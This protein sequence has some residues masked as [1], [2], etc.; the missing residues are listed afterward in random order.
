[1]SRSLGTADSHDARRAVGYGSAMRV[2]PIR[3]KWVVAG[4]LGATALAAA[5]SF[6][7]LTRAIV[8]REAQKRHLD[9]VLGS[10][11]PGW[12]AVRLLDVRVHPIE[13]STIRA[14]VD[15]VRVGLTPLLGLA[16]LDVRGADVVLTGSPE[17]IREDWHRMRGE[18][19]DGPARSGRAIPVEA[20]GISVHWIDPAAPEL[21]A[22]LRGVAASHDSTGARLA[23]TDGQLRFGRIDV[24]LGDG[25]AQTDEHGRLVRAHAAALTVGWIS[26]G[27]PSLGAGAPATVAPAPALSPP[28]LV[29]RAARPGRRAR[30]AAVPPP[31]AGAPLIALPDLHAIRARASAL[32]ALLG[33]RVQPGADIGV[34]ALTWK[35]TQGTE[36]LALTFGPGPMALTRAPA[37]LELTYS[38]D[39]HG[40]SAPL[41]LRL[42]LPT[43]RGDVLVTG[44]GGP[45][46]LSLL[47]VQEGAAGLVDVDRATVAGRGRVVLAGD[48]TGLTFDGDVSTHGL[49]LNHPKLAQ[50]AVRGLDLTLRARGAIDGTGD[51]RLDD[52]AATL[53]TLRLTGSGSLEQKPDHV[54]AAARFDIPSAA[55]QSLLASLPS[56]LLPVLEE[57]RMKGTFAAHGRFAFDTRSLEDLE[58]RYEI[59]DHCQVEEVP[60]E[61]D[62]D[63][64]TRPFTHRIYLP[65]GSTADETTGPGTDNWAPLE[66]VSPYMQIAVLTT[67]DGAFPKHHGF[68]HAAIRSSI[69]ANLKAR[70][71]VR[72]AS[73]I[74]MQL[75]KNLFLSR[76]KT[77]SRK[78]E[79][80][81][82]TDYLEQTFTKDE[83][84]ELYLNVIE[85]GPAVYGI[86]A[87]ADYYFGRTPAELNLAESL[88]LASLLPAPLRYSAMREGE[89]PS[90]GWLRNLHALMEIERKRG[91]ITDAELSEGEQEQILFWHGGARPA[92]RAA[93]HVRTSISGSDSEIPDPFD[94]P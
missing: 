79:E 54:A 80:V 20:T 82:L 57:T 84:M 31:D 4:V 39:R 9:V 6:V 12:L 27:E 93:V 51:V 71:F 67:E 89:Q 36:R 65:D 16:H 83:I 86:T 8:S 30:S 17:S 25:A 3:Q 53:G 1:M 41:A 64:F 62:H 47:G 46:S 58:L 43:D 66:Q 32:A 78:L 87:G 55:C 50:E 40:A 76:D 2:R 91:L 22:E 61:L 48:G 68:N 59:A 69:V 60:V 92:P 21:G 49:S 19:D 52:F 72:G 37:Q 90:E 85:F 33:E 23:V 73:T 26:S 35:I 13:S 74:T 7:P 70:R 28:V 88:F 75:A 11:R 18:R 44:E 5:A 45:V 42:L 94:D 29:A 10:V 15:E 77:L 63:T 14:H 34:D 56:G 81:V 38:T 24:A